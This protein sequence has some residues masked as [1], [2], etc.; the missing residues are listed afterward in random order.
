MF[1]F[2]Y[3]SIFQQKNSQKRFLSGT[4]V[5]LKVI[6]TSF[7]PKVFFKSCFYCFSQ[8]SVFFQ[9]Q[10]SFSKVIF[11]SVI[12][13]SFRY[14]RFCF[15]IIFFQVQKYFSKTF[16]QKCFLS[17]TEVFFKSFSQKRFLSGTEVMLKVVFTSFPP[18][19]F[20]KSCFYCFSQK[21]VFFQVQK[22]FSKVIFTSV[23]LISFRYRR[24]C[25]KIVFFQVQKSF[26]KA[27]SQKCFL[28]GTEV[29]FKSV[30]QKRFL[31]GTEVIFK[32]C[33]YFCNTYFF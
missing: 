1:S 10:K 28:S 24:F 25:F 15:K 3:R 13:I 21:S 22:S 18:K 26:S 16:S 19:V 23:I 29:F 4:E 20:F 17:G 32:S 14:R 5:P 7:P 27:F 6:F 33:F 31:S 30:S 12:L 2:R 11:T 9:V 8:K